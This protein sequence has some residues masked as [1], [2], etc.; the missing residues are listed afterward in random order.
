MLDPLYATKNWELRFDFLGKKSF[1]NVDIY[2][3][4]APCPEGQFAN[5]GSTR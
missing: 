2:T 1:I 3:E 4:V 5:S